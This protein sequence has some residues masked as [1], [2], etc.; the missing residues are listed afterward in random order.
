MEQIMSD[1]K[2]KL[3][4]L[5]EISGMASKLFNDIKKSVCEIIDGYK[6]KHDTKT[7]TPK[8]AKKTGKKAAEK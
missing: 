5:N 1:M 2:S 8:A 6:Q 4:D 7:S 3:P